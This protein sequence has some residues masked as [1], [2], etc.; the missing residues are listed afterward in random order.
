M[1]S[2]RKAAKLFPTDAAY[3]AG[4][5]DGESTIA[6]TR[7]H[8]TDQRQLV[9]SISNTERPLLE[10]VLSVAGVGKIT[11]KKTYQAHHAPGLTYAVSNRQ[12]LGVLAQV[13]AGLQ[14]YNAGRAQLILRDYLRLTPR[15]G[16]YTAKLKDEREALI[17]RFL[18]VKPIRT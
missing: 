16:R 18:A 14:T 9:V 6:L 11:G 15:N 13:A 3:L 12:A 10:W 7:R 1:A 8:R 2:C 5:I 4:L 17:E